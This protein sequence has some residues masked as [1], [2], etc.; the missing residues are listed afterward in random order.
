M[1]VDFV[2]DDYRFKAR[3]SVIILNEKKIIFYYLR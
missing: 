2:K 1:N 3:A